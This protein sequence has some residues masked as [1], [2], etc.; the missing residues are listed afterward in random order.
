MSDTKPLDPEPFACYNFTTDSTPWDRHA[1][2]H[3]GYVYFEPREGYEQD[4]ER[5]PDEIFK[6]EE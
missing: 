6:E 4:E 2:C 5:Y 1:F 3:E